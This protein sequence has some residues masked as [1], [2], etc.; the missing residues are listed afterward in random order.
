V[1]A[2]QFVVPHGVD[3]VFGVSMQA[4]VPLHVFV[5]HVVSV[6]VI[7]VPPQVPPEHTSL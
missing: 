7:V 4:L 5:M 3:D 2:A 6:Q 1:S